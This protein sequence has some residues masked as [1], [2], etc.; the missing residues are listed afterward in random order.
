MDLPLGKDRLPEVVETAG[1]RIVQQAL[2]N[3]A[4]HAR[5]RTV[6]VELRRE[7]QGVEILVRDDGIGFDARGARMRSRAGES[8]GLVDM[9]EMAQMAGGSLTITSSEGEGSTVR[10]RL[11]VDS[12]G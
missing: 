10:V 7:P 8:L 3:I 9:S 12:P 6:Y 4:R 5:A 1:F 2:T 11:P